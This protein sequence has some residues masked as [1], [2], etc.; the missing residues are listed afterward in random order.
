MPDPK[1]YTGVRDEERHETYVNV[2]NKKDGTIRFL[3]PKKKHSHTGFEW[4]YAGS[5]PAELAYCILLDFTGNKPLTEQIYQHFKHDII[6]GFN[7]PTWQLTC[8]DILTWLT[9]NYDLDDL[10]ENAVITRK[11][12]N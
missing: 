12:R 7:K 6:A 2:K 3:I 8:H 1:I 5:G 11:R 10:S 4:G 9:D